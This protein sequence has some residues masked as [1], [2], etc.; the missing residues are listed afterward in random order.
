MRLT[1]MLFAEALSVD[2]SGG[3]PR[4]PLVRLQAAALRHHR[5]GF[6]VKMRA[7]RMGNGQE[8][9]GSMHVRC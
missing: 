6:P 8:Y 4:G 1:L 5:I 7:G 9:Q 3:F 2:P